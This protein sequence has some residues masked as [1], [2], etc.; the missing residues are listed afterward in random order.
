MGPFGITGEYLMRAAFISLLCLMLCSCGQSP[1]Q[2]MAQC[3]N[4][5]QKAVIG[6]VSNDPEIRSQIDDQRRELVRSCMVSRGFKFK[7]SQFESDR[8]SLPFDQW[9]EFNKSS[10]TNSNYWK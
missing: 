3:E 7:V 9:G 1:S 2:S 8:S 10:T 4:D 5:A 6:M